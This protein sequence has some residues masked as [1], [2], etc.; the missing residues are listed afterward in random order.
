MKK[1][2]GLKYHIILFFQMFMRTQT[3]PQPII[4]Q[5]S[6]SWA[7]TGSEAICSGCS[8]P[9]L[10]Q[11]QLLLWF[12]V[13]IHVFAQ[14][15]QSQAWHRISFCGSQWRYLLR[16]LS[17]KFGPGSASSVVHNEDICAGSPV[18]VWPRISFFCDSLYFLRLVSPKFGPGSD[19]SY[20]YRFTQ[21][22]ID[23]I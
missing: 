1:K 23:T 13:K 2:S 16:L 12:T 10:A 4:T 5:W 15:A 14:A 20:L 7:Q 9:S 3:R 22:V 21:A 6:W 19:S 8:V 18:Q 11:D 17:P